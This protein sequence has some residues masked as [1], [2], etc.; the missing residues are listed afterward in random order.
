MD[1]EKFDRVND[2]LD[3]YLAGKID[4]RNFLRLSFS[5][6]GLAVAQ[7]LLVACGKSNSNSSS[8]SSSHAPTAAAVNPAASVAAGSDA[9]VVPATAVKNASIKPQKLV[10]AAG[11]DAPTIDPSDRTDYSIGAIVNQLYDRLFRYEGG[12]PQ[13]IEAN[14]CTKYE[15]SPDGREWTF[16]LTDKAKFHDGSPVTADAVKYSINR[17]LALKKPRANNLL[18]I[19]D[20]KSVQTPDNLTVKVTLTQPYA[21][22]PRVLSQPIM[23][24]KV[25]QDHDQGGDLGQAWLKDHEAGSGPFVQQGWTVGSAYECQ[26]VD[27]YWQGWPGASHLSGFVWKIVRENTS[28]RLSLIAKEIDVADNLSADDIPQ[29]DPKPY[30]RTAVNYGTLTGYTKLNNTKEPTNNTDFRKFLGYAFD[31]DGFKKIVNGYADILTGGMPKGIPYFDPSVGNYKTDLTQAKQFLTKTPW[32]NG[33]LTLDYVYVT[34]LSY[35]QQIGE[36]W[37]AQLSKFNIKVNLIPK[38]FPDIVTG[39]KTP[40]DAPHMNMIFTG[41]TIPDQWFF[42]QWYSP[43]WDRATGGDYNTCDFLKSPQIDQLVQKVRATTDETQKKQIYSDLQKMVHDLAP[44]VPIYV[45]PNILGFQNRVQGYKYF[46]SITVDFWRL[47][48][49]DAKQ[50]EK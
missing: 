16:H 48:I 43:N 9:V 4:R 31:Y 28:Q 41:Y 34:G 38:V 33:G 46:G 20:D 27:N 37:L 14:L 7:A 26:A 44:D 39:C 10:Y 11:Q 15:A 6:G 35:E 17:T 50:N 40:N 12:W 22:L 24:P 47:W 45:Q 1:S 49:D 32:A 21:E 42:F 19:M 29:I 18:P 3:Q 25:V 8:S 2:F 30:L 23:N 5:V 13:P 36:I